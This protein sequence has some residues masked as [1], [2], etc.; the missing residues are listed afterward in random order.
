MILSPQQE[1]LLQNLLP[2]ARLA[3]SGKAGKMAIRARTHCLI[4]GPS[5]AGKSHLIR[6]LASVMQLPLWES[7]VSSWIPMGG[8]GSPTWPLLAAWIDKHPEGIIFLDELDKLD[9]IS[10]WTQCIRLEIHDLLDFRVPHGFRIAEELLSESFWEKSDD[11]EDEARNR[12]GIRLRNRVMIVGAGAWQ[13]A[14]T[15]NLT[16]IG[17]QDSGQSEPSRQQMLGQISA[18][19]LQRFRSDVLLLDPLK[20]SDFRLIAGHIGQT[21]PDSI[22]G[23]FTKLAGP[24]IIRAVEGQLGMRIFEEIMADA[25]LSARISA[26]PEHADGSRNHLS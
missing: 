5:G 16:R 4:A 23:A 1:R 15:G 18:E 24:A 9:G 11:R 17:Y 6:H 14:W 26:A 22:R 3:T 7:C 12:V 21:L 10:D 20:E 25:M 2:L 8:R 19:I 13:R